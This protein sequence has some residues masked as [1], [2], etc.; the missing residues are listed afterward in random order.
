MAL[1]PA[2]LPNP[3]TE[4]N[5]L[6]AQAS[7][8]RGEMDQGPARQRQR[9]SQAPTHVGVVCILSRAQFEIF[10]GWY[11]HR[12]ADGAAG[13]TAPI[14]TGA[15]LVQVGARF[16]EAW[17]ATSLG[18]DVFRLSMRWEVTDRPVLSDAAL[19]ALGI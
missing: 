16:I 15:G 1:W 18:R 9:F 13:F 8:I 19:T 4:G 11:R 6:E 5:V 2:A 7:F 3:V 10:E 14:Y 12:I 17:Q